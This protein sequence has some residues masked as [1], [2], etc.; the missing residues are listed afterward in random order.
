MG[1]SFVFFSVFITCCIC[2][3]SIISVSD[4]WINIFF[5][6]IEGNKMYKVLKVKSTFIYEHC[7]GDYSICLVIFEL[8]F[9]FLVICGNLHMQI[10]FMFPSIMLCYN[11][12]FAATQGSLAP[13]EQYVNCIHEIFIH[14]YISRYRRPGC[15]NQTIVVKM[16]WLINHESCWLDLQFE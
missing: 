1:N 12:I 9:I 14:C 2:H 11:N 6:N 16:L 5:V 4:C 7:S 3:G 8:D 10:W 15:S 13:G